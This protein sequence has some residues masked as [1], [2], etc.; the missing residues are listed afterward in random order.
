MKYFS[1]V[2]TL[3]YLIP[4]GVVLLAL[5][6]GGLFDGLGASVFPEE[7][8][9]RVSACLVAAFLV[10]FVM[11]YPATLVGRLVLRILG[12]PSA[13]L[14]ATEKSS[15]CRVVTSI[16]C[17]FPE[18]YRKNLQEALA[19]HWHRQVEGTK[20]SYGQY[21]A[22]CEALM[23]DSY[24]NAWSIHER[25]YT[26]ANLS[27]AMILPALLLGLMLLK[28]S[29]LIAVIVVASSFVF[30]YRFFTLL[31]AATKQVLNTFYLHEIAKT[32]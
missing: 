27:R 23:E 30:A 31:L 21:Y 1:L 20:Y 12:N 8:T 14:L 29:L 22:L 5:R 7:T 26:A 13:Y 6:A 11:H 25:F 16:R 28:F 2:D 17:D 24:P 18:D 10:G 3:T 32:K 15:H 19:K 4:G 9:I